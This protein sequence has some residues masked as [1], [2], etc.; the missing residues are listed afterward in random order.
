MAI[1][2]YLCYARAKRSWLAV[3]HFCLVRFAT[4]QLALQRLLML[5]KRVPQLMAD[6]SPIPLFIT[7]L[8]VAIKAL[9]L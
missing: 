7:A 1:V 3:L 2:L 4:L 9:L 8:A 6:P 5:G